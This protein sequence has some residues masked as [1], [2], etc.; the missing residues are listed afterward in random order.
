[1]LKAFALGIFLISS[2]AH[3]VEGV[4]WSG[5][6]YKK[7]YQYKRMHKQFSNQVCKPG[8]DSKYYEYLRAYRGAGFYLPLLGDDIDRDAI[9]TNLSS[10]N[11]KITYISKTRKQLD[12]LEELP[13]FEKIAEPLKESLRALLNYKKEF[14]QELEKDKKKTIKADSNEELGKLRKRFDAFLKEVFFLKSYNFPNDHLENR[15]QYE[16]YKNQEGIKNQ[17]KANKIFFNR[18]VVEDGTYDRENGGSDLYLRSTL[19]TLYL[20]IRKEKDFVSENLRYDLEWTLRVIESVLGRTLQEQ[21]DRLEDWENRTKLNQ[22]FYQDI[23]KTKNKKKA[24]KMVKDKND[25]SIKLREYV[26]TKQAET[27]KW[28]MKKPELMR[29]LFVL[30]TILFNE[31]GRVDGKDALERADV[32]QIVLNR[33]EH[34]FYSTLDADQELVKH[35][36]L[37]EKKY[38]QYPWLNTLFRVGEFSFT[39]HYISSVVKIFCPDMSRIGRDLRAKNVKISLKAIKDHKKEFNV[40]RYFSRVS[41]LGKI[42]MSTVWFDYENYPERPGYE[43]QNQRNLLRLFLAGKYQYLYSFTDPEGVSFQVVRIGD[44]TFSV[45]WK[46]G[47][48]H[49]YK[50]RDPHLF[51]YFIK[52]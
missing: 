42:D 40:L 16:L 29:A 33:V 8:T 14:S 25:A 46:R 38:S 50:Y 22:D 27:Y 37:T 45:S 26:Y 20:T 19:D 11:K 23:I 48:P 49:F 39:Y 7:V 30:E 28:W 5:N 1:M 31:V 52:K 10:F 15:K 6:L 17:K 9:K 36:N 34:P 51:K 47:R 43:I 44:D 41:M 35:L 32:A 2:A 24:K 13:N 3:G 21:K 18:K 4:T 12:K